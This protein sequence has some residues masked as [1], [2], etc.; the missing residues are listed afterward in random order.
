MLYLGEARNIAGWCGELPSLKKVEWRLWAPY[1]G[2]L[3]Q[4]EDEDD[5]EEGPFDLAE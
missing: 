1:T 2:R 5:L 3:D 4:D